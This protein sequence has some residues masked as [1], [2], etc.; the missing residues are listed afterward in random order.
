MQAPGFEPGLRAWKA[1]VLPG[2][3]T[4]AQIVNNE[5]LYKFGAIRGQNLNM[6]RK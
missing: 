5:G 3:T 2:Y 6:G 1:L 4:P